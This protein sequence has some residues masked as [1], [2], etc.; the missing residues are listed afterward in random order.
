[1][2]ILVYGAG[3]LGS[4]FAAKLHAAGENVTILGRGGRLEFIRENGIVIRDEMEDLEIHESVR[5]TDRLNP[6]DR[7]DLVLVILRK[8][9]VYSIL[10]ILQDAANVECFAFLGNNG[11]G[12]HEY[13]EYIPKEK[14]LLG[15]AGAAGRREDEKI[16]AIGTQ[17]PSLVIGEPSGRI[18]ERLERLR[19]IFEGAGFGVYFEEK[20][21]AWLKTHIALVSPLAMGVYA[22][23]GDNYRVARTPKILKLM[24][25]AVKENRD[26]LNALE[27]PLVPKKLKRMFLIPG[28][29]LRI[30][31]KKLYDSERGYLSLAAHANAARDE[32]KKITDEFKN[33]ST[34][35]GVSR[36]ANEEL[37][38]FFDPEVEPILEEAK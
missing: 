11:T 28:F 14:I 23:G 16:Y 26:V 1:M 5:V 19:V 10:P 38:R 6:E 9:Q 29:L 13:E 36:P 15:F 17:K 21:D 12:I 18:T 20:I 33:L 25:A 37:Y 24:V 31:L 34:L 32:M 4:V 30:I 7:Y 3:V 27:I 22:G 8:N 35:S 2:K